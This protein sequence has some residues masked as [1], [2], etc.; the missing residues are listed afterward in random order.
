MGA[1]IERFISLETLVFITIIAALFF[2]I[3]VLRRA[4]KVRHAEPMQEKTDELGPTELERYARH[5]VLREWGG[6]GQKKLKRAKVLVIGAGGLGSP[7]ISYLAAAGVGRIGVI[8]D[9]EVSLSNLQRQVIY[10]EAQ[11]DMPKVFAAKKVVQA[12]NPFI[13]FHPYHRK[14][15]AEIAHELIADYDVV[16]DTSD[17]FET[18]QL[19]NETCVALSKPM[20]FGAITQWEGQVSV[21][22]ST[23]GGCFHCLFPEEPKEG[24]A[25]SCAEA[26]V[27][28]ALPGVIGSVMALE[29]LKYITSSGQNLIDLLLIYD[30]LS[31]DWRRFSL[32]KNKSCAVCGTK[33]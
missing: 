26:G 28:G 6:Q 25:P 13:E 14:F 21:F 19:T 22:D 4:A 3:R 33:K 1:F 20:V 8:D 11:L 5:I 12:Q 2:Y 30:S 29:C 9:D 17:S 23:K 16:I 7:V 15:D 18:R 32:K 24:L 10:S 31:A 27:V